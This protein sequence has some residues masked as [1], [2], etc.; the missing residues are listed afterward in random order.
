LIFRRV[1]QRRFVRR[2]LA[3]SAAPKDR[4]VVASLTTLPDRIANLHPTLECLLKQ[5]RPPDEIV[6]A[7]PRFSIRQQRE[8]EIPEYLERMPR[9]RILRCA[10]DCGPATKFIPAIQEQPRDTL[11]FVVDD[12]RT[13][14]LDLLETYLHFNARLPDAALCIRGA[15]MP[16]SFDW[17]DAV[18]TRGDRIREPD[19]VAVITGAGSYLIQPR[20]FDESLWDYSAAPA[21]AFHMDDIWISGML[22]R[23]AVE[24]HVVPSSGWIRQVKQQRGTMT[25]HD[26]PGGRQPSNNEVIAHFRE[27]W[28]VFARTHGRGNLTG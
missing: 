4:R 25:L 7:I 8:Y 20:L 26:V 17:R 10:R 14:P 21:A 15:R 22:D 23:G 12:D 18:M 3:H 2:L 9:V 28:N 5:T 19:R 11:I 16:H 24:K 6:I 13:Y 27:T 1:R